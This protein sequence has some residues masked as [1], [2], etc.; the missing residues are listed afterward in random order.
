MEKFLEVNGAITFNSSLLQ[1]VICF[2]KGV[3][4]T[5]D[6]RISHYLRKKIAKCVEDFRAEANVYHGKVFFVV[7]ESC[8]SQSHGVGDTCDKCKVWIYVVFIFQPLE[9]FS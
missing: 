1:S 2:I 7:A 8:E 6:H 4:D 3:E 5:L 9:S